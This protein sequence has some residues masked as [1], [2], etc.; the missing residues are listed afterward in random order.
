MHIVN[1]LLPDFLLI[2]FG[3]ILIRVTK[4]GTSFW[5]GME[6]LIYYV[7]FPALLFY[8]TARSPIDF[9]QT[10]TF[11]Q[12]A[13]AACISG[14]VLGWLARPLFKAEPM[15]F[16]S[17]VQT[18]FRFNSYIALAIASRLGGPDGTSLM[19]LIIGFA[20]PLSNMAAVHALVKNKGNLL[21]ELLKNPLLLA[22][23]S[24]VS[25]NLAGFQL[26][27]LASAF[28][29]RLG[30]ASIALGLIMVGAGLRMSG[31]HAAKGLAAWLL[32]VKLVA[33]PAIT[34][35]LGIW[36]R[37]PQEQ[38]TL[39]VMFAALPTASSCYVLA[40]RMGGNGPFTA[41]LI[42]AGTLLSMGTLPVW[43]ALLQ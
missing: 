23:L 12:I 37:L 8:S 35:G 36:A 1:I 40:V 34:Y 3:A 18:A 19:G 9:A 25:F 13:M 32:L 6:R 14:I 7:L 21:L 42:S 17:G 16:A 41:F 30:N 15:I 22:T 2:L 33:V 43:L 27:E 29:S 39:V 20:V 24:G 31:L 38:L 10:G 26:P 4:W 28:L 11:L 5:E